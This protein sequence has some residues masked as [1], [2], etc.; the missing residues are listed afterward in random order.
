M[1][2]V[3]VQT[4]S[5]EIH[6]RIEADPDGYIKLG[7]EYAGE[8]VSIA[9]V[10]RDQG[11]GRYGG[12]KDFALERLENVSGGVVPKDDVYQAY[13]T[14]CEENAIDP[15]SKNY[16]SEGLLSLSEFDVD[17][18]RRHVDERLTYCYTGIQIDE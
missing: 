1:V 11:V 7:D 13:V 17:T 6:E 2:R 9:V 8:T 14:F 10:E 18:T 5:D 15:L 4:D 16:F 3:Q 12:V